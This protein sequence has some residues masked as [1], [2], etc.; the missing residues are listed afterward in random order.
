ME[1][2]FAL[3][4]G[5]TSWDPLPGLA[6]NGVLLSP[7]HLLND[8]TG[9]ND[10]RRVMLRLKMWRRRAGCAATRDLSQLTAG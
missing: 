7:A 5:A 9:D 3:A 2:G 10:R 6:G 8:K 4:Y 1:T